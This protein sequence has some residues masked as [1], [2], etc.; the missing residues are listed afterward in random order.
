MTY[1]PLTHSVSLRNLHLQDFPVLGN[2]YHLPR[3]GSAGLHIRPDVGVT[4]TAFPCATLLACTWNQEL[5]EEIGRAG[6]MEV[7]DV[8]EAETLRLKLYRCRD[9]IIYRKG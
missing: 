4:T 5:D 8:S 3:D 6:G 2:R 1:R 7:D 9:I